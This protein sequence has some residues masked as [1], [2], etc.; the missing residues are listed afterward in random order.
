MAEPFVDVWSVNFAQ[1]K[2]G[3]LGRFLSADERERAK[4]I[5][6]EQARMRFV[7]GRDG[8]RSILASYL[9]CPAD[10]LAFAVG[11]HGKPVLNGYSLAFNVSHSG[12]H[13]IVAVSNLSTVGIDIEIIE[14]RAALTAIG[15]RCLA[16]SEFEGWQLMADDERLVTFFRLWTIKE[17]FVKA[18]GRGIALGLRQCVV[19]MSDYR[20]LVSVPASCGN[21]SDWSVR[22][23]SIAP[24]VCAAL[25]TPA[26]DY[27][28]TCRVY[29][30]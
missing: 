22:E 28:L 11:E 30:P 17:A 25:V 19:D 20:C 4:S 21:A 18:V 13:W 23:L 7:V 15:R 3:V 6:D 26:D 8:L 2:A 24:G 14:P 29:E 12:D 16:D 27:V 1:Q 5:A 10:T 9:T